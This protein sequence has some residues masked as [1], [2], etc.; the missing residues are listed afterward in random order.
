MGDEN[1][2]KLDELVSAEVSAQQGFVDSMGGL[3]ASMGGVG[4]EQWVRVYQENF[5]RVMADSKAISSEMRSLFKLSEE[6]R[7]SLLARSQANKLA[8]DAVHA[9]MLAFWVEHSDDPA[10]RGACLARLEKTARG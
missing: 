4:L 5:E 10:V 8:V 3:V 9:E 7:R 1:A 6:K 2:T